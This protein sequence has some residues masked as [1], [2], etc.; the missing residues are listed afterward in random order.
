MS[1]ILQFHSTKCSCYCCDLH[2]HAAS[3]NRKFPAG[4]LDCSAICKCD[5]YT[6]TL[7]MTHDSFICVD[8]YI[9]VIEVLADQDIHLRIAHSRVQLCTIS[10]KCYYNSNSISDTWR[11]RYP[12]CTVDDV[13]QFAHLSDYILSHTHP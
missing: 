2:C 13:S 5:E 9:C 8:H 12:H 3:C 6:G 7:I 11:H 10:I 4:F 1:V